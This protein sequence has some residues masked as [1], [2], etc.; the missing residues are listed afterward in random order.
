[1]TRAGYASLSPGIGSKR[2]PGDDFSLRKEGK[3]PDWRVPLPDFLIG[4]H[5][6]AEAMKLVTR[7]PER[8]KT[9]FPKVELITPP[10][11]KDPARQPS[12]A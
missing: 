3:K 8:V 10:G 6:Q 7:D 4:A 1:L 9:Y 12:P 11:L 5:A 2:K